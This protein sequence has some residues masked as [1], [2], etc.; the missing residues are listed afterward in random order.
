MIVYPN[1]WEKV[2][3]PIKLK[4][5]EKIILQILSGISCN[6]LSLSG[7]LD[8]SL[9]LYYMTKIWG[10]NI[11]A[12]TMALNDRHPDFLF[13]KEIASY[14]NIRWQYYFPTKTIKNE[15]EIY[16]I[17]YKWLEEKNIK[18]I[19]AGDG[20]DE[21][22]GGYYD[23]M[24]NPTE[25]TYYKHLRELKEKHLIPLNLNSGNIDIYLPYIDS[26]L[27]Y[28]LSQISISKKFDKKNRKKLMVKLAEGKLPDRVINRWKYGFC[29]VMKIKEN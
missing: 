4:K 19:I 20:I 21:F 28:L 18:G 29:D 9:L 1:D 23:Y 3:Q 27:I 15:D 5:I 22:M 14:F 8:S 17:F 7:G 11:K 13:S 25:K 6:C 26:K 10:N 24:K 2:G 16:K 12:Y